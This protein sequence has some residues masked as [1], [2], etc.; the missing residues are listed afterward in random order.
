MITNSLYQLLHAFRERQRH[1][2]Q[3][4]YATDPGVVGWHDLNTCERMFVHLTDIEAFVGTPEGSKITLEDRG[5]VW[6]RVCGRSDKEYVSLCVR[7]RTEE[8]RRKLFTHTPQI[9]QG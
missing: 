9:T 2:H 5:C 8:Q 6:D 4:E 1:G 3:L 7:L